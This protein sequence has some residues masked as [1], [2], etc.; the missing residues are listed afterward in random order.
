M[1]Q[2]VESA[3]PLYTVL[4]LVARFWIWFLFREVAVREPGRVPATGPVLLCVNHP[5]N[6][7]DSLLVA[8]VVPRKIHYLAN[9]SLFRNAILA[10]LLSRAGAIPVH[11]RQDGPDRAD[12]NVETFAAARRALDAGHVLAIYPEGT[13]HAETRV[14]HIKTGAARIALD[15]ETAQTSAPPLARHPLTVVPVGLSFEARKS[16]RGRVLVAFGEPL[17]LEPHVGRNRAEPVAAVQ[18]LTEAIQRAMEAQV[19]HVERI[20][21]AE[22]VQAVEDLYRNELV[23]QLRAE[24]GLPTEAIDVFRLSRTIVEA[25]AHFKMHDPERVAEIWRR[26]QHYRALLA[27]WR[28]RDQAVGVRLRAGEPQHRLRSSGVALLGLPVFVYGTVVNALPYLVPRWLARAFAQRETDYA[29]IRLLSSVV[30]VPLGWGL[31]TWLVLRIAGPA[32]ALVFVASLPLSGLLAYHY[33]RGLD[34]LRAR[35]RFA[36]LALTRRHTAS[37]LLVERRELLATLERAKADFLATRGG[38]LARSTAP[39]PPTA[40]SL[41]LSIEAGRAATDG[42]GGEPVRS[43]PASRSERPR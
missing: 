23:R 25:V 22:V 11:R 9:A 14:Q 31:E 19:V 27:E 34:R 42:R 36:I 29:T 39:A 20:D 10:R 3:G 13:T 2:P 40:G 32:W 35:T 12:R 17:P 38:G 4:R 1:R 30:A 6:L 33:L 24:R 43:G 5:N 16:F 28:V 18:A 8:A 7:I 26:I 37:R 41:P 15:Y 21:E